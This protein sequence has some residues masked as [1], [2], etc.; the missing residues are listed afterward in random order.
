MIID[1]RIKECFFFFVSHNVDDWL[2]YF[3]SPPTSRRRT[4]QNQFGRIAF[5]KQ[6]PK[7]KVKKKI[8]PFM[9][10]GVFLLNFDDRYRKNANIC[11]TLAH[12][13]TKNGCI[14]PRAE[15]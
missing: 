5:L 9:S 6:C 8:F 2:C 14:N 11:S 10:S 1:F 12:A 13:F 4:F 3:R 15:F 7:E